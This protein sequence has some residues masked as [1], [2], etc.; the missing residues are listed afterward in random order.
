MVTLALWIPMVGLFTPSFHPCCSHDKDTQISGSACVHTEPCLTSFPTLMDIPFSKKASPD[1]SRLTDFALLCNTVEHEFMWL[2]LLKLYIQSI[3]S[4]GYYLPESGE[5][6]CFRVDPNDYSTRPVNARETINI[7][8]VHE[9]ATH[10]GA[11]HFH[12][13]LL[14]FPSHARC[15]DKCWRQNWLLEA[16][17]IEFLGKGWG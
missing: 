4:S 7:C 5:S 8:G 17:V 15:H 13:R 12:Y 11:W 6:N 14:K 3:F 9:W 16:L 10:H 2:V 1:F